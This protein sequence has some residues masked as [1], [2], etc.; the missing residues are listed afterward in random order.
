MGHTTVGA[1]AA[2]ETASPFQGQPEPAPHDDMQ[3]S[4][5][6]LFEHHFPLVRSIVS[7]LMRRLPPRIDRD[8]L[9]QSG[10]VGLLDA[11]QRYDARRALRFST[12]AVYR[13]KCER[14]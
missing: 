11:A 14:I 9:V 8:C 1:T 6:Q 13:I 12:Y 7:E 5:A 10:V 3:A 2:R 4:P